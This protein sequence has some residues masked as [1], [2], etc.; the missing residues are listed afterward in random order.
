M[1]IDERGGSGKVDFTKIAE[2][3]EENDES[4]G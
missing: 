1:P 4:R 3:P 2:K